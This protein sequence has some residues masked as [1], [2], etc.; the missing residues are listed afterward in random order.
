MIRNP[1]ALKYLHKRDN[2]KAKNKC[3]AA[4]GSSDKKWVAPNLRD[5]G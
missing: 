2:K 4:K 5:R 3:R 1:G